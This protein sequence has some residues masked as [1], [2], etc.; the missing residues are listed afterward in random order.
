MGRTQDKDGD[1][2]PE[3]TE[4][5]GFT[6]PADNETADIGEINDN[7]DGVDAQLK[8]NE[9]AIMAHAG[10]AAPHSG[11][12]TPVGATNKAAAAAAAALVTAEEY[13]DTHAAVTDPHS[14]TAAA[15]ANRLMLRDAAGRA[16]VAAPSADAD[17]ARKDTVDA[18]QV[19]LTAHL[20]DYTLQIPY[21]GTTTNSGNNYSLATPAISALTAGMAVSFKI[22]ADSSGAATLNWNG[23]GAKSIKKPNG[24]A[25][26]N[27]KN[28]GIYTV[29]YDGTNFIAQGSDAAGDATAADILA[30]KTASVD[31]G[32]ITGTMID[33]GT[34]NVTPG[35][36]NQTI[37]GGKHSGSGVVYGDAD[38]V[39]ANI[40]E[41]VTIF[42]VTGTLIEVVTNTNDPNRLYHTEG[43]QP[44]VYELNPNTFAVIHYAA[45]PGDSDV[46]G[47]FDRLYVVESNT[48]ILYE[49]NPDTLAVVNSV[50]TTTNARGIGGMFD[51]L[52][53]CDITTDKIYELNPD[54]L[55]SINNASSPSSNP[56]GVGGMFNR[57][58]NCDTSSD[59]NYELNPNTLASINSASCPGLNPYG[60]GGM[61]DRLYNSVSSNDTL[62]ELNPD[63][64]ASIN[65]ASSPTGS[66]IG[67]GGLKGY[68]QLVIS[69][70]LE[71]FPTPDEIVYLGVTY[72]KE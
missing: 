47:M 41:D 54:T 59:N 72:V 42:G 51:R 67:V 70:E 68:T 1:I 57:L 2:V 18:V 12:E 20:A 36:T 66:P 39:S 35:T 8:E 45:H 22:N 30:G 62:Y 38:L 28:G 16:Q 7:M 71:E 19:N 53:Y 26:S 49:I 29:R 3:Y 40:K 50:S 33:R 13:T 56:Y 69:T 15:T 32:D 52:Y 55:A 25:V 17:I 65:S 10:A 34:V 11:H 64:L 37:L 48:D 23:K 4:N 14:A 27:L 63:T 6:K 5:Y 61:F 60:I 46:G 31:A 21:G 44:R 43:T 9:D 24:V 58:Y